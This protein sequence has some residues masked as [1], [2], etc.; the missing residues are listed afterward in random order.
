[1][2]EKLAREYIQE[3]I[4]TLEHLPVDAVRRVVDALR[5]AHAREAQVFVMGNGG[6]AA[7]AS[8]LACDLNKGLGV[9]RDKRFRVICL[10]D[11]VPTLLAYANDVSYG[12]V[13]VEQLRN[14]VRPGDV[15][16]GISCSG[17]SENV[18]KAMEFAAARGAVG[19]AVSGFDGGRLARAARLALVVPSRDMQVL[20]DVHLMICHM[21]FRLLEKTL[22]AP[23]RARADRALAAP[24]VA[25]A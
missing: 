19:V 25:R 11:N 2:I 5:D 6:S 18:V 17:N 3:G 23:Q 15:V 10:N 14:F 12:D 13:F 8:H 9:G 22:D 24:T 4:R 21:L 1:M 7:T 20:E 16:I